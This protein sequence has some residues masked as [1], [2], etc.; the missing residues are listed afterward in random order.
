MSSPEV[1][2]RAIQATRTGR[3]AEARDLLLEIV[4]LDP[5]NEL[6]WM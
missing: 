1:L 2:Q 6:A 5:G 3:K 4:E